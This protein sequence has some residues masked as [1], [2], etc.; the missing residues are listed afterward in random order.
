MVQWFQVLSKKRSLST[1]EKKSGIRSIEART[2]KSRIVL[3]ERN[4]KLR[5]K[6]V[7]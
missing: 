5:L 1:S 2:E 3:E 7:P 6:I 4:S